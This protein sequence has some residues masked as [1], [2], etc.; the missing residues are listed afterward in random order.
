ML[1]V[2]LFAGPGSGKSTL[3]A[4]VFAA[5]KN[6]G[7]TAEL[8]TEFAKDLT[9]E[10]RTSALACQ[11]FVFGE[12]LLR[13]SRLT[14][15]GVEVAITDSPLLLSAVYNTGSPLFSGY[16]RETFS[17]FDNL[18]FFVSR[19]K[20]YDPVGRSQTPDEAR[21]L[22]VRVWS[23]LSTGHIKFKWV[24]GDAS[25]VAAVCRPVFER[26]GR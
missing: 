18:N 2:N 24:P 3:A 19:V 4:G 20:P 22:D 23:E 10:G 15:S 16:V 5:L 17:E 12:Q 11:P 9:W 7:V 1:V 6:S 25:G 13:L 14:G 8:V 26:L 21:Q